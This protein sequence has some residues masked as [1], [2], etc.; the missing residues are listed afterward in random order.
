MDADT[1]DGQAVLSQLQTEL[2]PGCF[3][4]TD[5]NGNLKPFDHEELAMQ[6][7]DALLEYLDQGRF[8]PAALVQH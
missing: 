7:D 5:F 2:A 6:D 8:F 1:A 3:A 4:L